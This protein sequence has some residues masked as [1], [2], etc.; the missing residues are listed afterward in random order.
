M[1]E[2]T[3]PKYG[4]TMQEATVLQWLKEDGER[5]APGEEV[6]ELE[7]DKAELVLDVSEGGTLHHRVAVGDVVGVGAVLAVVD[8]H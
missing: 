3:L 2:V 7:T 8:D 6:I 4:V 5:V 1:L